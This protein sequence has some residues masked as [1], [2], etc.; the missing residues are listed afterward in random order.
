MA[1]P[2]VHMKNRLVSLGYSEGS[3][4]GDWRLYV[5]VQPK[6]P[7]RVITLYDAGGLAPNPRWLL[8]YPSVQIRVRGN[9]GD[10]N[11]AWEQAKKVRNL[12]LGV[13]SYTAGD[14]DR[15]VSVTAIGDI[16]FM[17][18]DDS[19]RPE[20]VCNL[21]LIIEPATDVNTQREPL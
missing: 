12:L 19:Q 2:A 3:G 17:G 16:A 18:L 20:H 14:G 15:I 7:D 1:A 9:Q 5:G 8:D 13:A 11:N 4:S 21:R 6:I 10:Y